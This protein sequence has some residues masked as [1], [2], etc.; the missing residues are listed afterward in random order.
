MRIDDII[1]ES[2]TLDAYK[3]SV[4]YKRYG[5]KLKHGNSS[6]GEGFY[7]F[8]PRKE[9]RDSVSYFHNLM[10]EYAVEKFGLPIRNLLFTS[11]DEASIANYGNV[12]SVVPNDG[13]RMFCN[14]M[15]TDVTDSLDL[16][17][18][19]VVY[20]INGYLKQI[21]CTVE[22]RDS[23]ASKIKKLKDLNEFIDTVIVNVT[24]VNDTVV[25]GDTKEQCI[26]KIKECLSY[27]KALI[28]R[29]INNTVEIKLDDDII[30]RKEIMVYPKNGFWLI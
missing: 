19:S 15:I 5:L 27:Y 30:P 28:K 7:D 22:N 23:V 29:Y 2:T 6:I 21:N 9:S 1:T 14:P 12:Y 25:E 26:N 11:T 4:F 10:N 24:D 16:F 18:L 17:P 3:D 8:V 13:F 20:K